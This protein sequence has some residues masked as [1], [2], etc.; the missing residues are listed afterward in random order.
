MK[1]VK[2][3]I[4]KRRSGRLRVDIYKANLGS[5]VAW[6]TETVS[7]ARLAGSPALNNFEGY[8]LKETQ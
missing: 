2:N 7:L 3:D 8:R 5:H 4:L 1:S 6:T